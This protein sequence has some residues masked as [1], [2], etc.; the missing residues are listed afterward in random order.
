[1]PKNGR[2]PQLTQSARD[3]LAYIVRNGEAT[4]PMLCADLDLSRPTASAAVAEL[5]AAELVEPVEVRAGSTGRSAAVYALARR[6][7][8]VLG[9]DV[10]S[11]AVRVVAA[12]I[13]GGYLTDRVVQRRRPGRRTAWRE[14]PTTKRLVGEVQEGLGAEHGML[15]GIRIAAPTTVRPDGSTAESTDE[16]REFLEEINAATVGTTSTTARIENNVNCS[17]WAEH[18]AGAAQ[19]RETSVFLQVGVNIGLGIV[20]GNTLL[21]GSNG[22]AGE[23]SFMPYPW[24]PGAGYTAEALEK[25]IGADHWLA[26]T[27]AGWSG[28]HPPRTA[29]ELLHLAGTGDAHARRVVQDHAREIGRFAAAIATVI[30]PGLIVLGGGLGRHPLIVAGVSRYLAKL[31]WATQVVPTA[32]GDTATAQGAARLAASEVVHALISR[33]GPAG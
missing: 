3:T 9:M 23:I 2:H 1:V 30:D 19:G 31:P 20:H 24:R 8:Y 17:A 26:R 28:T 12:R 27:R 4:R 15:R 33:R 13:D 7:G 29:R 5:E 6:S 10:G 21:T 32:L 18:H 16:W 22:A 11:T 25:W 14:L